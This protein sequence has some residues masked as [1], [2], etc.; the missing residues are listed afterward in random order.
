MKQQAHAVDAMKIARTM[1]APPEIAECKMN[2]YACK[3]VGCACVNE[4]AF[5]RVEMRLYTNK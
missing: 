5:V 3:C 1:S 4:G 2:T